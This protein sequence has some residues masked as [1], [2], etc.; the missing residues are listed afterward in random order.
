MSDAMTPKTTA[1]VLARVDQAWASLEDTVARLSPAELTEVR[2]P[3]GWA[4]KDHLMH[5]AAWEDA[6]VARLDGRPTHEALGLDEATLAL[7][8]DTV[9]D[10]IFVRHR[11]R[12]L[13]EVLNALRR[14]H[15]AARA[16]L[17]ALHDRTVAG[18]ASAVLSP[19]G[20]ATGFSIDDTA[21]P[22]G[23]DATSAAAW[24]GGNTWEHYDAHHGWIREL[25]AR[26]SSRAV[27]A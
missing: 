13:P 20:R 5:V 17:A 15:R 14:S 6:L 26:G 21:A 16:R 22:T 8:E 25:V 24:I 11:D 12:G 4:V 10:A 7:D 9:N 27:K 1:D 19:E 18:P 3:A 23:P 2:D